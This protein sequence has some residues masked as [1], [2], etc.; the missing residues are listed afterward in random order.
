MQKKRKVFEAV[1]RGGGSAER[2]TLNLVSGGLPTRRYEVE[3]STRYW[4][5]HLSIRHAA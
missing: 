5:V 4:C 1:K 3:R 2:R